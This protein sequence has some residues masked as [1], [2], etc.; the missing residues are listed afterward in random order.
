MGKV[1]IKLRKFQIFLLKLDLEFLKGGKTEFI[2]RRNY[3]WNDIFFP[4]WAEQRAGREF[5]K[6]E[7]ERKE[8]I[9]QVGQLIKDLKRRGYLEEKYEADKKILCLTAKGKFEILYSKFLERIQI[10]SQ[11]KWDGKWRLVIFDIPETHRKSRNILRRI[12]KAG[13]VFVQKSA[14]ITPFNIGVALKEILQYLNL[15]FYVEYFEVT[16]F[17]KEDRFLSKFKIN[18]R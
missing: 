1:R 17:D 12:L 9:R 8:R 14:L 4:G 2:V 13:F 7:K 16:E 5:R 3:T 10:E 15:S 6:N 11:N 18:R